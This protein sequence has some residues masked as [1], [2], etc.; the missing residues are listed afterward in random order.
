MQTV[1][2]SIPIAQGGSACQTWRH[3][4]WLAA[5]RGAIGDILEIRARRFHALHDLLTGA[6]REQD[7]QPRK[8]AC[9]QPVLTSPL[10]G[11][12]RTHEEAKT[13]NMS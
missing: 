6:T 9:L 7:A 1:F 5:H 13:C 10:Q 8:D 4:R 3:A 2:Q 11:N 12:V